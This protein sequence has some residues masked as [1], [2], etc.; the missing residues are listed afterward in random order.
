[1]FEWLTRASIWFAMAGWTAGILTRFPLSRRFWTA[2]LAL[3][4]AHIVLAFAAFYD[5][6]QAVAWEATAADTERVTGWRSGIGLAFNYLFAL[7]LAI[8]VALQWQ[9]NRRMAGWLVEG[10]VLFFIVNGAV[11]FA[12]GP[13]RW[14]GITMTGVILAGWWRTRRG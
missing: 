12:D 14:F 11:V 7:V 2:G 8:D 5:W 4:L 1:M 3:Y 9:L 10:L 6:S 13:V